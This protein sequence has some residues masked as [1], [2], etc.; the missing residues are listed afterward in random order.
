MF[1][2]GEKNISI[3]SDSGIF[4][5]DKIFE[6]NKINEFSIV[7][8]KKCLFNINLI[9][10][11]YNIDSVHFNKVC[12][13]QKV[14]KNENDI[15]FPVVPTKYFTPD[16][17]HIHIFFDIYNVF[18]DIPINIVLKYK[19]EVV[20]ADMK[21]IPRSDG[22][23]KHRTFFCSFFVEFNNI[24]EQQILSLYITLLNGS[25][26]HEQKILLDKDKDIKA[27]TPYNQGKCYNSSYNFNLEI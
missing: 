27:Q 22:K 7:E 17:N 19:Q 4:Y 9:D 10:L 8:N 11:Y 2:Y 21:I 23:K 15:I 1:A 5:C 12:T 25:V 3:K 14:D 26:V 13:C 16:N 20:Y 6:S 24:N 18:K